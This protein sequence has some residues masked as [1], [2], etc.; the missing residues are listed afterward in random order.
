[1]RNIYHLL[2]V[3]QTVNVLLLARSGRALRCVYKSG[4]DFW[5][6]L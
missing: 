5:Q 2:N 4:V 1:M 6:E 3:G